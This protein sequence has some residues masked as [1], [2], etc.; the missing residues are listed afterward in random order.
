[1]CVWNNCKPQSF[2]HMVGTPKL[3]P[4][5]IDYDYLDRTA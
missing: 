1:M 4:L 2:I 3:L 5:K